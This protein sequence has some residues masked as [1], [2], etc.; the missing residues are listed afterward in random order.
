MPKTPKTALKNARSLLQTLKNSNC[1]SSDSEESVSSTD[2]G[3]FSHTPL[4]ST[5][6]IEILSLKDTDMEQIATQLREM[7]AMME[8][9]SA[10]QKE[11]DSMFEQIDAHLNNTRVESPMVQTPINVD[12]LF[13]IP[14]PIKMI[15]SYEGSHKQLNAWLNTAEQTLNAF[16]GHVTPLQYKMYVTAVTSKIQGKAKDII[17]LAGNPENFESIKEVLINALGDRQELSTYKCQL[18]QC[19]M[20]EGMTIAKYYN[21]SKGIVQN[22]KTLAKQ[23]DKYKNHWEIINDFIEEDALA[24]F[25]AGLC[26]PYFGYAQAA[27]PKDVEDAY[28]F[29]CKFKSKETTAHAM[30]LND[31]HKKRYENKSYKPNFNRNI[32]K[33]NKS[34]T[35]RIENEPM[36]TS[37]TRS[38]LTLNKRNINNHE[39][40]DSPENESVK[41]DSDSEDDLDLNFHLGHTNQNPA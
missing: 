37:T 9:F 1:I 40:S 17:C 29:L 30:A 35:N 24:A 31:N 7:M 16:K 2:S 26:E 10:K 41:S 11:H 28:A 4:Q 39:I 12:L 18:W 13:K 22:I 27:R 8:Q 14:D 15:P 38:R 25:I 34:E 3:E 6:P 32:E 21:K 33:T 19:K 5:P 20:T 36:D 23:K